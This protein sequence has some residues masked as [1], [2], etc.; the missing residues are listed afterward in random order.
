MIYKVVKN[1][2]MFALKEILVNLTVGSIWNK[3]D[4]LF[5]AFCMYF[6]FY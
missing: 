3:R 5:K 1:K 4:E 2:N 6:V